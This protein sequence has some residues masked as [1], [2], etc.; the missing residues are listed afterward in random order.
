MN[1]EGY[2]VVNL[3]NSSGQWELQRVD[4][5]ICTVFNP[6][7][8]MKDLVVNHINGIKHDNNAAN[9]EFV[10]RGEEMV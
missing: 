3:I 8:N 5:L 9:L 1:D 7:E 6:K 10:T 2:L 4:R